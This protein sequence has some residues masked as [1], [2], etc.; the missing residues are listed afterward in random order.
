MGVSI[1]K[2]KSWKPDRPV[3]KGA[4]AYH[5]A[6][7]NAP[8]YI[9][10]LREFANIIRG[11]I[12]EKDIV[13]DFGA[14]TGVSALYLLKYLKI[15]FK[16]WLVD[17][18][19]AWLGK[20]YDIFKN[21]PNIK[22]FLLEKLNNSYEIL[23]D[24]IGEGVADKVL[25]ANTFHLIPD[26]EKSFSGI[27]LALK[28]KG[29]FIFQSAN[30]TRNGREKGILMVDDTVKRVHDIALEI[31]RKDNKFRSYRKDLDKRIETEMEQ[32]KFV[33]PDPRPIDLYIK[34]LREVGFNCIVSH[35]K[36]IRIKYNDWLKF[37]RVKR[38]QAGI[39]PE[40]GGKTPQKKEEHDR[41]TL[42]SLAADKLFKEL[43]EN[44]PAADDKSFATEWIYVSTTKPV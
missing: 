37:L 11:K 32:R 20:A 10:N 6:V 5:E 43:E 42:I 44:N 16:L 21:D 18:S 38:L 28:P 40:I 1:Q 19:A 41:D 17:N 13:I 12:K 22:F 27:Y 34:K 8:Y 36:T 26:L 25:S 29:A 7:V 9:E 23:A 14:G 31:I 4:E 3:S 24:A 39:L 33:F 15:R 30:I 2:P 35:Y